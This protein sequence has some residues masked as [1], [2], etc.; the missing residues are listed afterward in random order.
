MNALSL[1]SFPFLFL[2]F[3]IVKERAF[4]SWK[5]KRDKKWVRKTPS[6]EEE[7]GGSS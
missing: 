3:S 6:E 4:H 2:G 5:G 7:E 1:T